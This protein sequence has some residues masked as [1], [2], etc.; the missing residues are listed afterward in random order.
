MSIVKGVFKKSLF[1]ILPALAVSIYFKW[2]RAPEGIVAGWIFGIFNLRALTR[3]VSGLIG[4]DKAT[5]KIM[6]L[7]I[8]RLAVLLTVIGVLIYFRIVNIFGMVFGFTVV[9]I[10]ILIEGVISQGKGRKTEIREN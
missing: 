1:I 9:F 5:A 8:I 3:S 4:S 7:S 10:L 2:E 6:I